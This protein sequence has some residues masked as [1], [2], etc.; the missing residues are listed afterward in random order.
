MNTAELL[1]ESLKGYL[2]L[3]HVAQ[4]YHW[5]VEN[6]DFKELHQFFEDIYTGTQDVMD[7]VA[8]RIKALEEPIVEHAL[9]FDPANH[10]DLMDERNDQ[11][12]I[13]N[14]LELVEGSVELGGKIMVE[15][16]K[17]NDWG[18]QDM[19]GSRIREDQ[20][21]AWMLRSYLG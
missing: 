14:L 7:E 5:N 16:T 10:K 4:W 17:E 2:H 15:A 11:K 1:N 9:H 8:E 12:M 21:L 3:Y 20:K 13:K 6:T 18:T 19:F